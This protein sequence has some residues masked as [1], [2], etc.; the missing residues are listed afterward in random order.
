M[1]PFG[2]RPLARLGNLSE[3][4]PSLFRK[5]RWSWVL[6]MESIGRSTMP[7]ARAGLPDQQG[8]RTTT[9]AHRTPAS[10]PAST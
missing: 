9:F 5:N 6:G 2:S 3:I 4:P 1:T 8:R 10:N 7:A